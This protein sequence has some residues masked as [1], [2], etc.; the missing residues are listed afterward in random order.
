LVLSVVNAT[1]SAQSFDLNTT[2]VQPQGPSTLLQLTASTIDAAD[3][4]G[5]L[6]Q[7]EIKQVPVDNI[8]GAITVAPISVNVYRIPVAQAAQ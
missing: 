2:G 3:R 4:V 1:E 5:Q 7:V 6:P 8:S